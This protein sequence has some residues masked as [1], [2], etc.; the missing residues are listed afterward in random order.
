MGLRAI[1]G[2]FLASAD[3]SARLANLCPV[4]TYVSERPIHLPR[5]GGCRVNDGG[6][7]ASSFGNQSG[8]RSLA[9]ETARPRGQSSR[10]S[11][12]TLFKR[13][14]GAA[15]RRPSGADAHFQGMSVAGLDLSWLRPIRL[16]PP[17]SNFGAE[18]AS[19]HDIHPPK[20]WPKSCRANRYMDL[21]PLPHSPACLLDG[22][23]KMAE[24][25]RD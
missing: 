11:L 21:N 6:T 5:R 23:L 2:R 13:S 22:Y 19:S 10:D 4:T 15:V 20:A 18:T 7:L 1:R 14:G 3:W 9:L 25:N 12:L 16:P 17:V 8:Q 24:E